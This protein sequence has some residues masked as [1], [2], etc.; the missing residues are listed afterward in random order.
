MLTI[1]I[2]VDP[3][4]ETPPSTGSKQAREGQRPNPVQKTSLLDRV[5]AWWTGS[6]DNQSPQAE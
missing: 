4:A 1:E 3:T 6:E 5:K 2:H